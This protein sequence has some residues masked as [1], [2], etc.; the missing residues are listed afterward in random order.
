MLKKKL[1]R[2][3][4]ELTLEAVGPVLV[5]ERDDDEDDDKENNNDNN[6][7][8]KF[9]RTKKGAGE[10]FI[11]GSSL[12]GVFRNHC[13][14]ILRILSEEKQL[15][16][17]PLE[18]ETSEFKSCSQRLEDK[19]DKRDN[20]KPFYKYSCPIC[21][22]FGNQF[23]RG[24][25]YIEDAFLEEKIAKELP[26]RTGAP[27]NRFVGNNNNLFEYEYIVDK[28]FKTSICIENFELWQLGMLA[29]L[30]RDL[31]N[32][33]L[34]VGFGSARGLGRVKGVVE[35]IEIKYFDPTFEL[36]KDEKLQLS[37]IE[38]FVSDDYDF[39]TSGLLSIALSGE[40]SQELDIFP[41]YS[42]SE[43]DDIWQFLAE[44]AEKFELKE[45]SQWQQL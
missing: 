27:I 41:S 10:P 30:L 3:E 38:D 6:N 8:L 15:C 29:Y 18:T 45:G 9:L 12:K 33:E 39:L 26:T 1:N 16:C 24:R 5:K 14:S 34:R 22:L 17:D 36:V 13:E 23:T 42:L 4:I 19:G 37:G 2:L 20:F 25:I 43:H 11:P 40:S 21:R 31:A 44:V 32:E 7:K 28:E 35:R